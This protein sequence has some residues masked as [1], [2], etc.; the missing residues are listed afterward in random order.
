MTEDYWQTCTSPDPMLVSLHDKGSDR[1]FRLFC[2]Y[3]C[4]RIQH[5][6]DHVGKKLVES[7]ERRV[8]GLATDVRKGKWALVRPD[9]W[10]RPASVANYEYYLRSLDPHSREY[11]AG[12]GVL[13]MIQGA[14]WPAALRMEEYTRKAL[15]PAEWD[16]DA[17]YQA[18]LI[19]EIFGNPFRPRVIEP[20]WIS[21]DVRQLAEFIYTEGDFKGLLL[22]SDALEEAGCD[23]ADMLAHLRNEGPHFR[24]CWALDK[25]LGYE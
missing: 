18:F 1:K 20:S 8:A 12:W 17:Y 10:A 24:G 9:R 15:P 19:R 7:F 3:C 5:L 6:L 25:V 14:A 11:N 23:D 16:Q 22:L 2:C 21:P 4:R 13:Q